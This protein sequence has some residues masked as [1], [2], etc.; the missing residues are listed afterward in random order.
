[1]NTH[2]YS[3]ILIIIKQQILIVL[4][5][6]IVM[7]F[8]LLLVYILNID[9]SAWLLCIQSVFHVKNIIIYNIYAWK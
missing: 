8:T 3:C 5:I 1:M 7:Y 9:L 6:K 4:F 2:P